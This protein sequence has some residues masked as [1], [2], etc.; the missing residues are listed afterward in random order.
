MSESNSL[1]GTKRF[2]FGI[3]FQLI[4]AFTL[5]AVMAAGAAVIA[6]FS[7]SRSQAQMGYIV[8]QVLP[9]VTAAQDLSNEVTVF[10]AYTDGFAKISSDA[11]RKILLENLSTRLSLITGIFADLKAHGYNDDV[12]GDLK[13]KFN[14]LASNL[15]LQDQ[16][17][18]QYIHAGQARQNASTELRNM[19]REFIEVARPR[20]QQGYIEFLERGRQINEEIRNALSLMARDDTAAYNRK[21]DDE[22]RV[23]LETIINMEAGEMRANLEMVAAAYLAVGLL[24]EAIGADSIERV[25]ELENDFKTIL[26]TEKKLRLILSLARPENRKVLTTALPLLAFGQGN[27]SIFTLRVAEIRTREAALTVTRENIQLSESLGRSVDRLVIQARNVSEIA[28]TR[29]NHNLSRARFLQMLAAIFATGVTIL[30]GWIYVGRKVINRLLALRQ[31]MES[32]ALGIESPIPSQGNDEISDMAKALET[33]VQQRR[34][35]EIELKSAKEKA[36][37]ADQAKSE[38]LANMSHELRTPLNAVTGFSELLSSIA[39]TPKQ[40]NYSNAIK[41]AARNLLTL[42]NDILDLSKIEAGKMTVQL[43]EVNLATIFND[44]EQIFHLKVRNKNLSLS[45]EIDPRLPPALYLDEARIRQI[46]LNLVGNAVKFTETG[47][48]KVTA[49]LGGSNTLSPRGGQQAVN[50]SISIADTGT[51]I[52]PNMLDRIFDPFQQSDGQNHSKFEGTGLGLPIS[53]KLAHIMKGEITVESTP[54]KGSLFTLNLR[55]VGVP[56]S[57]PITPNQ[58]LISHKHIVFS[59]AKVLVVDDSESN[60]DFLYELLNRKNLEVMV[61]ENGREAIMVASDFYPDIILMDIRMP[62]MNGIEAATQLKGHPKTRHIP[63]IALTASLS[64]DSNGYTESPVIDGFLQKPVKIPDL[65][66]L[67]CRYLE[68][69]ED[70]SS[71]PDSHVVPMPDLTESQI[72][73]LQEKCSSTPLATALKTEIMPAVTSLKSSFIMGNVSILGNRLIQVGNEWHVDFFMDIGKDMIQQVMLF[74]IDRIEKMLDILYQVLCIILKTRSE[75]AA[76]KYD[77]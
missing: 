58:P 21:L 42:I 49:R 64:Y 15:A 28:L 31:S 10:A 55:N 13:E 3:Q 45:S 33:F 72:R 9:R 75:D 61:A 73:I 12:I 1:F 74:D 29:L 56:E 37:K 66:E 25:T 19:H 26:K 41:T 47:Y 53:R 76:I 46:L 24:N 52:D 11:D 2:R 70:K 51:G 18:S 59:K 44:I 16:L 23:G 54:S 48:V 40:L 63:V 5:V 32:Q 7:I 6:W 77:Q 17:S 39:S 30:I 57:V 22:L 4:T 34:Q 8:N 38:F 43:S 50:L 65:M 14:L 68:H 62:V 71:A 35:A 67:L 27:N 36:E 60:R 20:I 69:E